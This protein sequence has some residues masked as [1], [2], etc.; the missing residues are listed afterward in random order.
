MTL[1]NAAREHD[2]IIHTS[3]WADIV[4]IVAEGVVY[5]AAGAAV[6]AIAVVAAPALG[7]VSASAA[8]VATA[9]GGSCIASGFIAGAIISASK[10]GDSISQ[11]CSNFANAIFP[12]S[13]AGKIA[14]GSNNVLI[15]DKRAARAAG[16]LL[17]ETETAN[18]PPAKEPD[19]FLD[20]AS[21]VLNTGKTFVSELIQPTVDVPKGATTEADN[22]R[23]LCD[24][25][26][27]IQ[28]MAEGSDKVSINDLP[29]VRANDRSTC[30]AKVS[31]IVSTNVAI[32][33]GKVVVRPIKSGKLPGLELVYM[34]AS[35]LRGKPKTIFK[36]MPCMLAMSGIGMGI[37][38]LTNAV[39]AVFN[40]VHAATGAKILYE[41]EL[42]FTLP[43]RYSF[44]W[45]RI[46]NSRNKNNGLFGQGW[47]TAFETCVI[48]ENKGYCYHDMGGR[49]LR[50][51][52]IEPEIQYFSPSEGLIIAANEKGYLT[53]GDSDGS[54]WR[55]FGPLTENSTTLS[56][57]SI[58]DEYGNGLL[59]HYDEQQKLSSITDT[60]ESLL[61]IFQYQDPLHSQRIT[62]IYEQNNESE[63][64]CLATYHYN[65]QGQLTKVIDASNI[66]T[67]EYRYN[68]HNLLIQHAKPQGLVCDYQWEKF[69]D[70]RVVDY[71][72]NAGEH[73]V[74]DYQIDSKTTKVTHINGLSHTHIWNEQ[75]LV[76]EYIDEANNT[77]Q[78]Q[79][80]EL[81]LLSKTISPLNEQWQ[82]HYDEN[83]C[84]TEETDPHGKTTLTSW[85]STRDLISS[86]TL[87]SGSKTSFHYD[88]HHGVIAE[89]DALNQT[90]TFERDIFGQV[91]T[92]IDA[93][94]GKVHIAYNARGQ[95]T[96]YQDCSNK[97]THYRYN[98]RYQLI[99]T[100][101]AEH[102]SSYIE[103]DI[104]GRLQSITR[105][106]GWCHQFYWDNC[107][108]LYQFKEA[109]GSISRYQWNDYGLLYK[110][111][112]P[113]QG[114][115]V[116]HYDE[117]GRLLSLY[118]ENNEPYHFIWGEN[119]RLLS[120]IGLDGVTTEYQYDVCDRVI[121]QIFAANTPQAFAHSA[122]YNA[123]SQL[124]TK[125]TPDGITYFQYT[126]GGQLTHARFTSQGKSPYSQF[127]HF[128]YDKLGQLTKEHTLS[129][130]IHY[131]YDVLGNKTSTILP[132]GKVLK[133]LY[134]GSGHAL[135]INL[136]DT[137]I[138]EFTR[139]NLH[140]E[141]S[142]TQGKI[143]NWR[144]YDR[145]GRLTRQAQYHQ[146]QYIRPINETR[147]DY[148]LRHN[149]ITTQE[150]TAP[151]GWKH[152]QYDATDNLTQ[153]QSDRYS[154]ETYYY[155]AAAN[156]LQERAT[157][158]CQHNR[159]TEYKGI[160]YQYDIYGRTIEKR[161]DIGSWTYSY[162]AEHRL[163][164]VLHHPVNPEEKRCFVQFDYDPLGRRLHKTVEYLPALQLPHAQQRLPL[165]AHTCG[166]TT[167]LWEGL[168]LLSEYRHG[169]D[170]LYIYEDVG[171]YS[172]LARVDTLKN[173]Q[174][175]FYF[176]CQPNGSPDALVDDNGD[177]QWQ[178]R[179]T[180][181]G[182]TEIELG[183]F[184]Y[185]PQNRDQN[186]RFQ[187]QYLD[188]ETGLHYNTFRY[189]D[190]DIGRFTQ[191]DPIGLAGGLNLYQYAPNGLVWVDPW[192]WKCGIIKYNHKTKPN[193]TTNTR[194]LK[195][196]IRGQ[197]RAFNKILKT[198]GMI[199]LKKRIN[200]YSA[201]LEKEGRDYVRTL[202]SAGDGKVWL[203]EPDMRVGGLPKDVTR[204][205]LSRENSIIGGNAP[206]IARQINDMSDDIIKLTSK[207]SIN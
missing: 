144:S 197:I 191:H 56:L 98:S 133:T 124:I 125:Q 170:M 161:T 31:E 14:T 111:I 119:N 45:Q 158:P 108:R 122:R 89:T 36:N 112:N 29:A 10:L 57:L 61:V 22:D 73:C 49:E 181:W 162:N 190:P 23:I 100:E 35:M 192:G 46:Y 146:G 64:I 34:A 71:K 1:P 142:R 44:I 53:L 103:Y 129:G 27:P 182:K 114:S 120:E 84:L 24:K 194:E 175:V 117:R 136:D 140:R 93:N 33:G 105:A 149:L 157:S 99:E 143:V 113:K 150:E 137:V 168:R 188:R 177:I 169:V 130:K 200:N 199:G 131:T 28:Y 17:T 193:K 18:I 7:L 85:L 109:D 205:G 83:G 147:W 63:N 41:D 107:G 204:V 65:K 43:S 145:L 58:S 132:D 92:Q 88:I 5:A 42:D 104:A 52:S 116:R 151:Y 152:Y 155:D 9:V 189:Y 55:L 115:I 19:S 134:Y 110:S 81:G 30:E 187:G 87:P 13:P 82:Y 67:R 8:A 195:R 121:Q 40:P 91:I 128:E 97:I 148:D 183:E 70:W 80:N 11:G 180:S 20:Y 78:Y 138:T 66:I 141:I 139:D 50:F 102:G 165:K 12:P 74:I 207:L 153:R 72:T 68:D 48:R 164:T 38:R 198:E 32:G 54:C 25:H 201:T 159:L 62:H 184:H 75:F 160:Y 3:V 172:P 173:K 206:S 86:V 4:S 94:N 178:A 171:S 176:H 26:L 59:L 203:H 37:D 118:N 39:S 47:S 156:L 96:R 79:W 167:F 101:D 154:P 6:A 77:W 69:D 163:K 174:T 179:F 60:A 123:L 127:A 51:S 90:T 185:Y 76:T 186:L 135:Q 202:N 166:T 126:L 196:Q 95:M 2:E 21:M 15:N 106:E 16:R